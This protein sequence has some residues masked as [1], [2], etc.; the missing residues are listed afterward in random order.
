[1]QYKNVTTKIINKYFAPIGTS[2]IALPKVVNGTT[3][4][5]N[6][7]KIDDAYT[8]LWALLWINGTLAVLIICIPIKFETML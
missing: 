8:Y 7:N 2:P 1:M 4:P 6:I 3:I 5:T